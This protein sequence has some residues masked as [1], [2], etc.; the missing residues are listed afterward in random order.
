M[1]I[2]DKVLDCGHC[3]NVDC[4]NS[5]GE[6]PFS[7][8]RIG[9]VMGVGGHRSLRLVLCSPCA[10]ALRDNHRG[11]TITPVSSGRRSS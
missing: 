8:V 6:G 9:P 10:A 11:L 2:D 7:L 1:M 5:I 3:S 4:E